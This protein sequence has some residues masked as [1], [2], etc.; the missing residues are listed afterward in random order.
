MSTKPEQNGSTGVSTDDISVTR[1]DGAP[2]RGPTVG[3]LADQVAR[4]KTKLSRVEDER[5]NHEEAL[6]EEKRKRQSAEHQLRKIGKHLRD[7]DID[8]D[9]LV[10]GGVDPGKLQELQVASRNEARLQWDDLPLDALP[11]E[12]RQ[13]A[14]AHAEAMCI[15]PAMIVVPALSVLA[16]AVGNTRQ[17]EVKS[18]WKESATLWTAVVNPSGALKSP[19]QEKA[20]IPAFKEESDL[21]EKW[22]GKY[23]KWEDGERDSKPI[24][25][26]RL[27]NDITVESVALR[28]DENPRGLLLYRDELA[29]WLGSFNQY[30]EGDSDLQNWIEFYEGRRIQIDRK[31]SDRPALYVED[32]SVSVTG[33]IQPDVLEDRMESIHFQSGFAARLLMCEPPEK[34]RRF[35]DAG[36]TDATKNA[37]RELVS[38]L[39]DLELPEEGADTLPMNSLARDAYA[40]FFDDNQQILEKLESGPLRS[41]VAKIEAIAA[42]L[43]LVFQLAEDPASSE[44]GRD[45]MLAGTQIAKWFRHEIARIYQLH[46]FDECGVSD[47]RRLARR[48]P[49]GTFGVDKIEEVWGCAQRTAYNVKDRLMDKGLLEKVD[50][51]QYRSPA[52][53]GN[54]DPYEH[55]AD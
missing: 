25:D 49:T 43:A 12:V 17:I 44:V 8:P 28:H 54:S 42:R 47:Q 21:K 11:E 9:E 6:V 5:D 26:R 4:L 30:N 39:Y 48:L 29:G 32:P 41:M 46:G 22:D 51:G 34:P 23:Q 36:V 18:N 37:Y 24:R 45:P 50:T 27:V 2:S 15:N 16:G 40:D 55:F 1:G 33:T 52:A 10:E 14:T 7:H 19:A 20:L 38:G 3:E 31:S 53:S 35:N 13:Y